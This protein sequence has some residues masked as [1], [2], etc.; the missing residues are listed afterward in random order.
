[1]YLIHVAPYTS[2]EYGVCL[3]NTAIYLCLRIA[4]K[5]ILYSDPCKPD[6]H[7]TEITLRHELLL[8][9]KR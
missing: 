4:T 9:D 3:Q 7:V 8:L 1:V 6:V 2:L 5:R